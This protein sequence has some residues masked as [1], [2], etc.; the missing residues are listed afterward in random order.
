MR[1]DA[2][3]NLDTI[4]RT[5]ARLLAEDPGTSITAIAAEAGVSRNAVHRRFATREALRDAVLHTKLDAIDAI[6][7]EARLDRAP[8]AVALH[9][10]VEGII[11]VMRR[12]PIDQDQMRCD[13]ESY[14]RMLAQRER[15]AAFLQRAMDEGMIRSDLPDGLAQA[16]LHQIVMLLG[17][18]FRDLD[19]PEV[20]DIAVDTLLVGIGGS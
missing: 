17:R 18:Q 14:G 2:A 20:A 9:R 7:G 15:I 6:L 4:L 13:A 1:S 16:L 11:A 10:F 19:A 8:V 12:Y 3:R 5:G